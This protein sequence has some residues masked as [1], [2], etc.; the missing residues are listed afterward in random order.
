M[1]LEFKLYCENGGIVAV[2]K[3]MQKPCGLVV[4]GRV[5]NGSISEG[6]TVGIQ[7]DNKVVYDEIKRI[8]INHE[9]ITI[10]GEGQLI[11][12]CLKDFTK[13]TILRHLEKG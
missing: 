10:A 12:I 2:Q 11:G 13:D 9:G 6:N 3:I 5:E 8:E 4:V 1:K 7:K